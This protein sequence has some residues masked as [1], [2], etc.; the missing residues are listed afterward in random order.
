[1]YN[2]SNSVV[3]HEKI[4]IMVEINLRKLTDAINIINDSAFVNAKYSSV[5]YDENDCKTPTAIKPHR[6]LRRSTRNL[7]RQKVTQQRTL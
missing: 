2:S 3:E 1:M 6:P 4:R 7:F 5:E